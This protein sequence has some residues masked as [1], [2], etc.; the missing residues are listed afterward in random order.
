MINS[1]KVTEILYGGDY[2]PEQWPQEVRD[3]DM[4]LLSGAGVNVVTLNV[5]SW[6]KLQPSEERYD[7]TDLDRIVKQ[8]TEQGMKIVMAT[9]TAAMPAWMAHRYPDVLRK[10]FTGHTHKYGGRHNACPHSPTFQ[11][12]SAALAGKIAQ[13][14]QDQENIVAWHVSNEYGGRCY[15][16]KCEKAFRIWLRKKYGSIENLNRVW[17]TAFW[18][19]TF[20]DWDEIVVPNAESEHLEERRS[21]F[22]SITLD[23]FRFSTESLLANYR[24]EVAAIRQFIPDAKVTTNLMGH[25]KEV[26]YRAFAPYMDFISWD[27]YPAAGEDPADVA[28]KHDLMRGL[29]NDRPFCLM[30]QTP[31]VSNW[32]TFPTLKRPG[33]M[34]AI[35]YQA[36]AHGADTVMFFQMRQCRAECETFHGAFISHC[37][38]DKTRTYQ[39]LKD[40]GAE[41]KGLG[42]E[43]LGSLP[44][45][46]VAIL[47]DWENWWAMEATPGLCLDLDYLEEVK[48][49]YRALYHYGIPTDVVGCEEDL[50]GYSLLIA[51]QLYLVKEGVADKLHSFAEKGGKVVFST[52]CGLADENNNITQTGYPGEL[53]D[54]LGIWTEEYDCLELKKKDLIPDGS[55]PEDTGLNTF[56]W[57]GK[58]YPCQ[59]LFAISHLEGARALATYERAFYA[60]SPVLTENCVGKGKAYYL[61][62]RC[63]PEFYEDFVKYL[64]TERGILSE[65]AIRYPDDI[66]I[67]ERRTGGTRY[68]F[69]LNH[70]RKNAQLLVNERLIG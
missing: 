15:C 58:T 30:E 66:E 26:D 7:F 11:K 2:N 33:E 46:K 63:T 36:M 57:K 17:N 42:S 18:S 40:L 53:R 68:V 8:V 10:D 39:E 16:E 56:T 64:A 3:E 47:F 70:G 25:Y 61:G 5:F 9:S 14:F 1:K 45:S 29:K 54:I 52:Y 60:G 37:G 21:Q 32:Y 48:S 13:H 4:R 65:G 28:M 43:L 24:A 20:Y 12:Y 55:D 69:V 41:L 51:P 6:A 35:S 34:R 31:S 49:W 23:F 62:T 44:P 59:Y 19:H 50:S 38:S 67:T 22:P 27:N